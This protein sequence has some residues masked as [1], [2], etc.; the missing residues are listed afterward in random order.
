MG[1]GCQVP[2]GAAA[3][4]REGALTLRATVLRDDGSRRIDADASA[5]PDE[6]EALGERV[7]GLLLERGAR[8]L[9]PWL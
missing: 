3:V 4:V 7:A 1:G 2:M 5:P 8:E 6:A 9:L